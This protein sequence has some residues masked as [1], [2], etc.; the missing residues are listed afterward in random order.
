MNINRN[1]VKSSAALVSSLLI[2]MLGLVPALSFSSIANANGQVQ[3]RSIQIGN[4][5]IGATT[6]YKFTFTPATTGQSLV[7]DFC[8]DT[9]IIGASCNTTNGVSLTGATIT[10]GN[11]TGTPSIVVSGSTLKVTT[12]VA[13]SAGTAYNFTI[14]GVT[15]PTGTS[16]TLGAAGSFYGR[17]YTYSNATYG[18]YSAANNIG[19]DVDYGGFALSTTNNVSISATVM[20]TL[21]FC[22]VKIAPTNACAN[23][24][25]NPPTLT[26]GHGSPK[27]IDSSATDTDTAYTQLS[28]NASQG[29]VVGLFTTSSTAC[30]GLS[31]DNGVSCGIAANSP[32]AAI[33]A[34]TAKFG[35]L[36]ANG[37]GGTGTVTANA[38]YATNPYMSTTAYTT[39]DPIESSSGPT[40][41]V[42]SLLTYSAS[43]AT[44][45]QAGVYSTTEALIATGTF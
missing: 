15:N 18:T 24:A 8:Q 2:A 21:T 16:A 45:T 36:M 12:T 11:L 29:V 32:A 44:T 4:S 31:R 43:A 28:T 42:N 3:T 33:P 5:A 40:A 20:E 25:A 1:V 34:G 35:L 41:N 6:T 30:S 27:T 19:N 37:T 23:A 10:N 14:N 7:V 38:N 17:L 9:A 26:I 13:W 22:V 39:P